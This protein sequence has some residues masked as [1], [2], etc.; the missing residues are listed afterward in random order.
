MWCAGLRI[1]EG[2]AA[3]GQHQRLGRQQAMDHPALAL[4]ELG[5]PEAVEQFGD[6]AAGG[7]LDFGVGIVEGQAEP[8][9]ESAADR[10]LAGAHQPDQHDA[11]P[12]QC[13]R[14][15]NGVPQ[16][17]G[18]VESGVARHGRGG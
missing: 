5:F 11:P 10:C 9:G 3:G 15:R 4:A 7:E 6:G 13:R 2:A 1:H 8:G 12:G 18:S 17:R 16:R 14:Q